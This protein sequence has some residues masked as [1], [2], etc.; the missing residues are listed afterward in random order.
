MCIALVLL[1]DGWRDCADCPFFFFFFFF[2]LFWFCRYVL[3]Y[4]S[5]SFML[6]IMLLAEVCGRWNPF[7]QPRGV[8][9]VITFAVVL[10]GVLIIVAD[11][12]FSQVLLHYGLF[13]DPVFP[14]FQIKKVVAVEEEEE[15]EECAA[16]TRSDQWWS[17]T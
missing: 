10:A 7:L 15:E 13:W 1:S 8:P 9:G 5:L 11:W 3:V 17:G 12:G 2:F 14:V 6:I 4:R 16:S